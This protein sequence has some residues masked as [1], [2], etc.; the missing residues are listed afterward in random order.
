MFLLVLALKKHRWHF[1]VRELPQD[2]M[3][4][5]YWGDS[6][7]WLQLKNT[8]DPVTAKSHPTTCLADTFSKSVP[9]THHQALDRAWVT[10]RK[11][12]IAG[13]PQEEKPL[14]IWASGSPLGVWHTLTTVRT[15]GQGALTQS[16]DLALWLPVWGDPS[17]SLAWLTLLPD[18]IHPVTPL[19][20]WI[21]LSADPGFTCCHPIQLAKDLSPSTSI[22]LVGQRSHCPKAKPPPCWGDH[23]WEGNAHL[24]LLLVWKLKILLNSTSYSASLSG[25]S[26]ENT[27]MHMICLA[28]WENTMRLPKDT[29]SVGEQR[30]IPPEVPQYLALSQV[31]EGGRYWV[32]RLNKTPTWL[33]QPQKVCSKSRFLKTKQNKT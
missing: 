1:K 19:A 20:L 17:Q 25:Q 6:C 13:S 14:M 26:K 23:C 21:V 32:A 11:V 7:I 22:I 10:T 16:S 18:F 8:A 5:S 4:V 12:L 2:P 24:K 33:D 15:S 31:Q 27:I 3:L 29:H 30:S 28:I 9:G